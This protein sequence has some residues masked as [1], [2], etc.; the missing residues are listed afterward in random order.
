MADV[1]AH[2]FDLAA[3]RIGTLEMPS[4]EPATGVDP[5]AALHN[6]LVTDT[7]Y[8]VD[9]TDIVPLFRDAAY[10]IGVWRSKV[11]VRD[12]HPG[13]GWL[14]V[15]GVLNANVTVRV[16]GDGAL[17]FTAGPLASRTPVRMP[18]GRFREW[19]VEV[20]SAGRVTE[21]ILATSVQELETA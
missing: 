5:P 15:N 19:E 8:V 18:P 20:E 17:Y 3:K 16:Y 7:L 2:S 12:D 9:G 10:L 11:I 13:F 6:D 4:A 14:R 1:T 21:V